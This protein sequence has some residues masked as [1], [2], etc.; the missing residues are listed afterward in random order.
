MTSTRRS[1]CGTRRHRRAAQ[2]GARRSGGGVPAFTL[3]ELLTVMAIIALISAISVP[4]IRAV[5]KSNDLSQATSLVRTMITSAQGV[6]MAQHRTAGVVFFEETSKFSLP[7]HKGQ[8]AVQII[9]E[10]FDQT[11]VQ[12]GCTGFAYYNTARQYLPH[13]VQLAALTDMM[14][15]G[16]VEAGEITNLLARCIL[17]DANGQL[18]LQKNLATIYDPLNPPA[19]FTSNPGSYPRAYGDWNFLTPGG[20]RLDAATLDPTLSNSPA[21]SPGFF[22]FN[23][24]EYDGQ[25]SA[26]P[27]VRS[28]WLKKNATVVIVNGNTGGILK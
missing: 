5:S 21:S 18:I 4:A 3:I 12:S 15:S 6:A 1:T 23:K 16:N 7:V 28:D 9:V 27:S 13:G 19:P 10:A 17:F 24:A 8:T 2:A 11:G 14:S 20:I 26:P 25:P 22:L